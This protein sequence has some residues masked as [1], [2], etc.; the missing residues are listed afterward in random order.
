[1]WTQADKRIRAYGD[2]RL[3]KNG[4]SATDIL[5]LDGGSTAPFSR[6]TV[7]PNIS[8]EVLAQTDDFN[9]KRAA[10]RIETGATLTFCN[11]AGSLYRWT[12]EPAKH[13]VNGT[14]NIEAPFYGGVKQTYGGS[15]RMNI[16][17]V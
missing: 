8:A 7:M 11:G 10:F 12:Q 5:F 2:V 14:L 3:D 9:V 4:F 13:I 17:S 6:L 15:G 1:M 16:D